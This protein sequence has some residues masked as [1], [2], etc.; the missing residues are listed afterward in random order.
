MKMMM[1]MEMRR[2]GW[3]CLGIGDILFS[4]VVIFSW[5]NIIPE[6]QETEMAFI[7]SFIH[8]HPVEV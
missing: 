5:D 6:R 2:I 4:I 3:N 1:M 7:H 8:P